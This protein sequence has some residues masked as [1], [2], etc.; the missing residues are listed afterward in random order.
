MSCQTEPQ[1]SEAF[2]QEP[3]FLLRPMRM[4]DLLPV[5][6]MEQLCFSDS[7]SEKLLEDSF[8]GVLDHWFVAEGQGKILGYCVL[9]IIAGEGEIQRIAVHPECRKQGIGRKL[10]EAMVQTAREMGVREM[11]L[12]VRCGNQAAVCLYESWGFQK[13]AVRKDYYHDPL[14]DGIIMWNH[15]V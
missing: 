1:F 2:Q 4:E 5:A 7:W 9:R 11:T 12:E 14:E 13:E 3:G 8:S 15:Q 10:M 6:Q